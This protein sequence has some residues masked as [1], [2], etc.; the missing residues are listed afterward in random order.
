MKVAFWV[1][2]ILWSVYAS[3]TLKG[4]VGSTYPQEVCAKVV[5]DFRNEE[6]DCTV[7]SVSGERPY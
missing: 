2:L 6:P 3:N 5:H 4:T 1:L 7:P